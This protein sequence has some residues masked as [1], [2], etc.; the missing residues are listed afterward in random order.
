MSADCGQPADLQNKLAVLNVEAHREM[1]GIASLAISWCPGQRQNH[2]QRNFFA[3]LESP[4]G[5]TKR[6]IRSGT[7][8]VNKTGKALAG[9]KTH[10]SL[11]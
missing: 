7:I 10:L 4:T 2:F 8:L 3:I 5:D 9:R 1:D 11:V 6:T